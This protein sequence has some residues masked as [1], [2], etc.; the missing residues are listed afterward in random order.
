MRLDIEILWKTLIIVL[1]R[2][3]A[4]EMDVREETP[5]RRMGG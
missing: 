4:F 5:N 3:N 2:Q 1:R